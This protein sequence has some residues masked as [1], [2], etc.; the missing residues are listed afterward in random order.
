M[1]VLPAA[2]GAL[3]VPS[4]FTSGRTRAK[5]IT[6]SGLPPGAT[7]RGVAPAPG[8]AGVRPGVA[9]PPQLPEPPDGGGVVGTSAICATPL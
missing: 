5:T 2:D 3:G 7:G 8:V 1:Q 9:A 4:A 6:R